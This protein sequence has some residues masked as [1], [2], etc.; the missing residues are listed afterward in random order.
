MIT[1][2]AKRLGSSGL[3]QFGAAKFCPKISSTDFIYREAV[4]QRDR[5][6]QSSYVSSCKL[7]IAATTTVEA[8]SA[9]ETKALSRR[10]SNLHLWPRVEILP[11]RVSGD[12]QR[13]LDQS[14]LVIPVLRSYHATDMRGS[15]L[16]EFMLVEFSMGEFHH[17]PRSGPFPCRHSPH[18]LF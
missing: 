4:Q 14:C 18:L 17:P 16:T 12:W 8:D 2:V 6:C 15:K 9:E 13:S 3:H 10:R 5:H 7:P 11:R 1:V